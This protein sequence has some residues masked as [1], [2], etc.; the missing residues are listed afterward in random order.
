MKLKDGFLN[1][2]HEPGHFQEECVHVPVID[3]PMN[4]YIPTCNIT[5]ISKLTHYA[6]DLS[7]CSSE[8]N[9]DRFSY[10]KDNFRILSFSN[11]VV[12][13]TKIR[14]SENN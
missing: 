10:R 13:Q 5:L 1:Y 4:V 8:Q 9:D 2:F 12:Y 6:T 7:K 3:Y 11:Y 14:C